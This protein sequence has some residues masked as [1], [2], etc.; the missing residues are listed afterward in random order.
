MRGLLGRGF[1]WSVFWVEIWLYPVRVNRNT[2]RSIVQ[3]T[4]FEVKR[5]QL[6]HDAAGFVVVMQQFGGQIFAAFWRVHP[7]S[8]TNGIMD[9]KGR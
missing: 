8:M 2:D 1:D 7:D 5:R 4:Q 3:R 6:L 9:W